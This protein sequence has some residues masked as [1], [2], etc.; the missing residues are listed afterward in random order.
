MRESSI[1]SNPVWE[2]SPSRAGKGWTVPIRPDRAPAGHFR[3]RRAPEGQARGL[4]VSCCPEGP[5]RLA[6]RTLQ[7]GPAGVERDL[8]RLVVNNEERRVFWR[9]EMVGLRIADHQEGEEPQAHGN[10]DGCHG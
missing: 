9:N 6:R 2:A 3:W 8:D 7:L 4:P 5:Q 10:D 1:R